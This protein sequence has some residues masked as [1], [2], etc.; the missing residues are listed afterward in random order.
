MHNL[1]RSAVLGIIALA[2]AIAPALGQDQEQQAGDPSKY[3]G[4]YAF[5]VPD[6]GVIEIDVVFTEE[7]GLTLSA[8]DA[9]TPLIHI[10]GHTY[11]LDTPDYGLINISFIE[12]EDGSISA[13]T[14]DAADF[15]FVAPKKK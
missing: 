3:A 9:T 11:E 15:S 7:N 10:S 13:L 5:E 8:L 2:V 6:Y 4:A 14:L 12:E 1:L